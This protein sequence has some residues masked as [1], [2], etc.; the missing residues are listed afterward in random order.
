MKVRGFRPGTNWH[1][2]RSYGYLVGMMLV[3]AV[4]RSERILGAMKCRGFSGRIMMLHRFEATRT[5][6]AFVLAA[7][8]AM[9]VLLL[10]DFGPWL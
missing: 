7:S 1:T 2:Y 5:D 9:A 10:L 4:E 8:A 6:F 3:R